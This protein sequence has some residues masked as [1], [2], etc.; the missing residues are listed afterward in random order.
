MPQ[1]SWLKGQHGGGGEPGELGSDS[2]HTFRQN[3]FGSA[4]ISSISWEPPE[5]VFDIRCLRSSLEKLSQEVCKTMW[6]GSSSS[7]TLSGKLSPKSE[8]SRSSLAVVALSRHFSSS[9]RT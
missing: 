5:A 3:Q 1:G 4:L 7:Q 9:L 6:V 2:S 8:A